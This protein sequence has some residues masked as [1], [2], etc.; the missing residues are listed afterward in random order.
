MLV[1]NSRIQI[2]ESE[3]TFSYTR[4]S[5][6]GGQNVN[7]VNSRATLRWRPSTSVG[8]PADV[9]ERF[10]THY[11]ARLTGDGDLLISSQ[12]YR[13]QGRNVQDCLDKLRAM[14]AGVARPPKRRK[15]TR[16]T[17]GSIKRRLE[18]KRREG[19]KKSDRGWSGEGA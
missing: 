12:R 8:L 1:V 9:L 11:A 16:P 13:D 6:P 19:S 3:F 17:K 2:P 7:K 10:Q 5:G 4:S 18:Q 15:K 14:L